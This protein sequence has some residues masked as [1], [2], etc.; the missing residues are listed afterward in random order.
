MVP[1]HSNFVSRFTKAINAAEREVATMAEE[2][3]L[4][5]P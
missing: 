1:L 2:S 3:V 5:V 4:R